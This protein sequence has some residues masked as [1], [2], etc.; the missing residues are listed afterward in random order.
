VEGVRS[1]AAVCRRIGERFDYFE[2]LH[3]RPRPAV[4]QHQ[5]QGI[6]V[7]G[8]DVEQVDA[9]PVDLDPELRDRVQAGLGCAPVVSVRPGAAQLLQVAEGD[10]LGPVVDRL[11]LRP[12]GAPE[13][14]AQVV[15]LCVGNLD[16]KRCDR[17]VIGGHSGPRNKQVS[18][19]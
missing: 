7:R 16:A 1:V 17:I 2:E 12:A 18:A 5:R 6:G 11:A 3:D 10:A 8:P 13:A 19:P 4:A 15:E 9:E 14:V